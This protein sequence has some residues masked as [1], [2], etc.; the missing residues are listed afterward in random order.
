MPAESIVSM[1]LPPHPRPVRP[2][3]NVSIAATGLENGVMLMRGTASA[4]H[5]Q[6][7]AAQEQRA[8]EREGETAGHG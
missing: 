3:G 1:P 2:R 7:A 4:L 6:C 8:Q 5:A